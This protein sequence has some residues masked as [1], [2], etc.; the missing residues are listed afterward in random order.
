MRGLFFRIFVSFWVAMCLSFAVAIA[1]IYFTVP[2]EERWAN[3]QGVH[4]R[5]LRGQA[6]EA[7]RLPAEPVAGGVAARVRALAADL[8]ANSRL[9]VRAVGPGETVDEE[10]KEP[11]VTRKLIAQ[12]AREGRAVQEGL[13]SVAYF[14]EPLHGAAEGYMLL[15]ELQRPSTVLWYIDAQT[16]PVRVLAILI[17]SGIVCSALTRH[18]TGRLRV[19]RASSKR[20]AAGDL[21]ARVGSALGEGDDEADA[22]GRDLDAMA[23][24]IEGLLGAQQ[25]L[26]RD[27]SHELRSPLARLTVALE[28][29]RQSTGDEIGE[30]H[31][32]IAKEADRL[33]QLIGEVLTLSRLEGA[34]RHDW[35]ASPL[36]LSELVLEVAR[37]ADFEAKAHGRRVEVSAGE[38][39]T[40]NG[41]AELLRRAVEN[42]VRNALYFAPHE[43]EVEVCL[44]CAEEG[45]R[46][47]AKIRV[48][49]RGPG[50]PEAALEAIF[51]PFFRVSESRTR[52][53]GGS[54]LGL[55]ITERAVR[56]H[57]GS[58]RAAN[59]ATGGLIVSIALPLS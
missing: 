38:A 36:D 52:R 25:R 45:G 35:H 23:E 13:D 58:V 46:S 22:L 15:A 59:A 28:L 42:V 20:L 43:T 37:D 33:G 40:L 47:W 49:D 2:T 8:E 48:Q 56:L 24:R 34:A 10:A 5:A 55:A 11:A 30:H 12:A 54:G 39:I 50:V 21:S 27:V 4:L 14:V 18:F 32:R 9:R 57:G 1:L 3:W 51:Q 19:I 17:V 16:L 29:A 31:D 41:I 26:L 7:D 6:V 53:S 44:E